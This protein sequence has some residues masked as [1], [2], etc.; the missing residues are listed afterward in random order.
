MSQSEYLPIDDKTTNFLLVGVGGQGTILASNVLSEIG[1]ALGYDV[2]KAEIHGMS[3]RG[4]S[5]NSHVRWG[6][7]VYSP[8]IPNGETDVFLSFE[9]LESARYMPYLRSDA[10]AL[11][12]NYSITPITVTT[13]KAEYPAHKSITHMLDQFTSN[14]YWVDGIGIAENVGSSKVANVVLLGAL[15]SL[16]NMEATEWIKVIDKLVPEK[17]IKINRQAFAAGRQAVAH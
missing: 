4:G 3:Q 14:A 17:F 6:K 10:L 16:L 9:K 7:E 8:I 2:K 12:N 1:L 5:V 13:S 15:S 11:I